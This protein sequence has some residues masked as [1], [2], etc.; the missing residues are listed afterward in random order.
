MKKF[1]LLVCLFVTSLSSCNKEALQKPVLLR[2]ENKTPV[3]FTHVLTNGESFDNVNAFSEAPYR[4]FEKIIS[5][6]SVVLITETDTAYAGLM[7]I[8]YPSYIEKG[9]Y[10]LQ[11]VEDSLA[12]YGY[13][14]VYIED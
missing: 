3:N 7:F 9:K 10:T 6:P 14:C 2:I 1:F 4:S 11:I 5:A 8:D 13:N 12:Y